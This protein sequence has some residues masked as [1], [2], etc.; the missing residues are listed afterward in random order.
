MLEQKL[1]GK[2]LRYLQTFLRR[3]NITKNFVPYDTKTNKNISVCC[4]DCV[5]LSRDGRVVRVNGG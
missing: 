5:S 2:H 3:L 1:S 4:V